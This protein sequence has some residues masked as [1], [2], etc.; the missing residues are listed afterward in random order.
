M[1][2]VKSYYNRLHILTLLSVLLFAPNAMA[3]SWFEKAKSLFG[4]SSDSEVVQLSDDKVAEGLKQALSQ[5]VESVVS[6]MGQKGAFA[7][8]PDMKIEL[9]S[10][11]QGVAK[12]LDKVGM[13]QYMSD[14]EM[15]LNQAA[16]AAVPKAGPVLL[17]AIKN[18]ELKDVQQL[19]QGKDNAATEYFREVMSKPIS[20]AMT[21]VIEQ[22]LSQVGALE[23]YKQIM[24]KYESIP[25]L[26]DV[27][28][29]L[30]DTV[31]EAALGGI[32]D[33]LAKQ[34][35]DI[36]QDP[37]KQTTDLLKQMFSGG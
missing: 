11:L 16:E 12:A 3:E 13:G 31:K 29:N 27:N 9:P 22:S 1:V 19:Y 35:A 5:G 18:M 4:L 20:D 25:L 10:S 36:R 2:A 34:E 28:A 14:L 21:P 37:A 17:E 30:L 15:K 23:V 8:N 7:D 6:L 33:N 26:P 24:T 32:F